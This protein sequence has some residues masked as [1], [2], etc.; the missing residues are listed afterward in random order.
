MTMDNVMAQFQYDVARMEKKTRK[1]KQMD[2]EGLD[3]NF[4]DITVSEDEFDDE[5]TRQFNKFLRARRER[6]VKGDPSEAEEKKYEDEPYKAV[7]EED[8]N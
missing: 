5:E 8:G 3:Y 7:E 2:S 6:A 1:M 4:E